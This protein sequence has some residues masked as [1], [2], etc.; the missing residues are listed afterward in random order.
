MLNMFSVNFDSVKPL[1]AYYVLYITN[2]LKFSKNL[3]T[4][5]DLVAIFLK[6]V[7][8]LIGQMTQE[9]SN[10]FSKYMNVFLL[11]LR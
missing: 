5:R 9:N 7:N 3:S 8:L 4:V 10:F 2:I 1:S 11:T 6:S